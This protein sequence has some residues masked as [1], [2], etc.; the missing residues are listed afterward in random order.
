MALGSATTPRRR[1]HHHRLA[2]ILG[3]L[4]SDL[5]QQ[6]A[7][8]GRRGRLPPARPHP[9]Q[10]P[11]RPGRHQP[12]G[13]ITRWTAS[14][15]RSVREPEPPSRTGNNQ[16]TSG[17]LPGGATSGAGDQGL[18]AISYRCAWSRHATRP[19]GGTIE[20]GGPHRGR[21]ATEQEG[22]ITEDTEKNLSM[23][24]ADAIPRCL[25]HYESLHA[26]QDPQSESYGEGVGRD[27]TEPTIGSRD[28]PPSGCRSAAPCPCGENSGSV[29]ST[30]PGRAGALGRHTPAPP[31]GHVH[32]RYGLPARGTAWAVLCVE[33][34]D[35][36]GAS[37]AAP[38]ATG[39]SDPVAGWESHPLKTY[40][41]ARRTTSPFSTRLFRPW[42][43]SRPRSNG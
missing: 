39:W 7:P 4:R 28:S 27:Q 3:Q 5:A 16:T 31:D 10:A 19:G 12:R 34:F 32:S 6:L 23:P 18:T 40:T 14:H 37:T 24:S 30:G 9:A 8:R 1:P 29:L 35:G 43:G 42:P 17:N 22:L 13:W 41:F 2:T 33:G 21:A 38:T 11:S 36:F 15:P 25:S 20:A 26:V